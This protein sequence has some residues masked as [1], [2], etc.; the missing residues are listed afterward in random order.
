MSFRF[1]GVRVLEGCAPHIRKVLKQG[2]LY[3]LSSR[4]KS[5]SDVNSLSFRQNQG[6]NITANTLYNINNERCSVE[7][8]INAIVGKNGD[9]KS[10]LVEII[11]RILNNF[12]FSYGFLND[13]P[14]LKFIDNIYAILYYEIDSII[15]SIR[16]D[17]KSVKWYK[18]GNEIYVPNVNEMS[19]KV[20]LKEN[21]GTDI[22]YAMVI[23]Y[24]LYAY[25]PTSLG[26]SS[27]GMGYWIEELFH[28]NDSYQTPVVLN[29]MRINGNIDIN[30]EEYLSRQRLMSIFANSTEQ[31]TIRMVS[32]TEK[33]VGYAFSL[34]KES[35]FIRK[36]VRSYLLDHFHDEVIW[37]DMA[38][39]MYHQKPVPGDLILRF[40][41]FW[42][43][44]SREL[45]NNHNLI[46]LFKETLIERSRARK[47]DLR[48]YFTKIN[49]SVY[50]PNPKTQRR[51]RNG[52]GKEFGM[53][54]NT[55][56]DLSKLNFVQFYRMLLIL[57]VWR[58]L[59]ET[60]KCHMRGQRLNE[61]LLHPDIPRNAA[62]LYLLYKFISIVETYKGFCN[63]YYLEYRSFDLFIREWPNRDIVGTIRH[64][65]DIIMGT[66]DYRTLKFRQT[67]N[68][69]RDNLEYYGAEACRLKG[70]N[71]DY[72]ISFDALN[73][74]LRGVHLKDIQSYLP[75]PIFIGDIVLDNYTEF[76]TMGTLSS[77]MLQRLNTVGSLVYHLR[78]LD[79]EQTVDSMV[80][81]DNIAIILEEV[82]LYYHPE[83]QKS[84]LK[85]LLEQINRA[86]LQRIRRINLI[87]ITHSPFVLSDIL[88]GNILCLDHGKSVD[89]PVMTFGANIHDLLHHPFFMKYGVI[90]D[91]AQEMINRVI[92][93]LSIYDSINRLKERFDINQFRKENK[94]LDKYM[95]FLPYDNNGDFLMYDFKT[96]CSKRFLKEM[97]E[98]IAEP[99]VRE[100]LKQEYNRV[101]K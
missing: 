18:S 6:L 4:Y 74:R 80:S 101:F 55:S 99:I 57:M 67:V 42:E 75:C 40:R 16:C 7:I 46:A 27:S 51:P 53:L 29:P 64:D 31:D 96:I 33:A 26:I 17:G 83:Y 41:D 44:F 22:F 37:E 38:P 48:K 72:Y 91:F 82:E 3:L 92:V 32:A 66:N 88:D 24:S 59:T 19:K 49:D 71:F 62:M 39:F 86:G 94:L 69:L 90:G 76:F 77:G 95:G 45:A 20:F 79:D 28:K 14:S 1:A 78:N 2:E 61:V 5:S 34:E 54:V 35:K 89:V 73:N 81:Y 93:S 70:I 12:A 50:P 85:F 87:F 25:T 58:T 15:Y 52:F 23:N 97:I 60:D 56:G 21:L 30:R 47:T 10:T 63:G 100:A 11:L 98:L 8:S 43:P 84:Y 68:Y 9:G 36:S 13:Q 65:L